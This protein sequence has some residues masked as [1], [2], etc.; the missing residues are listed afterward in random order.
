M[1]LASLL[2]V[3]L[4]TACVPSPGA[5]VSMNQTKSATSTSGRIA[6]ET[7]RFGLAAGQRSQR[8]NADIARDFLE[9]SFKMES[10]RPLPVLTRFEGPIT[11]RATG[12]MPPSASTAIPES[13]AT[14]GYPEWSAA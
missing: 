11:V 4:L 9:L 13:S 7:N 5:D 2:S 14:A 8:N 1:R 10:G 6:A 12:P 3:C